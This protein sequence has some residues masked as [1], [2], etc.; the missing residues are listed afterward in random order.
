MGNWLQV[1]Q[2]LVMDVHKTMS[3][4][5]FRG[6]PETAGNLKLQKCNK[7][8]KFSSLVVWWELIL[9][10]KHPSKQLAKSE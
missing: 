5:V 9:T 8:V 10:L 7:Y 1:I 2:N 3:G 6:S 4:T